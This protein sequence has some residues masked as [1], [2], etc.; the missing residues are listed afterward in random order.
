MF[1]FMITFFYKIDLSIYLKKRKL[2]VCCPSQVC[3]V[4][5]T[6]SQSTPLLVSKTKSSTM[7][8]NLVINN[9]QK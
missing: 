6:L 1:V 5:R 4:Y 9:Y 3:F 2:I 7:L 8:V